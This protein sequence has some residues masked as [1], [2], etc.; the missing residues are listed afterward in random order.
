[1]RKLLGKVREEKVRQ[2]RIN[3]LH[4]VAIHRKKEKEKIKIDGVIGNLKMVYYQG[5]KIYQRGKPLQNSS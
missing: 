4:I 5:A 2:R 3:R 1:M